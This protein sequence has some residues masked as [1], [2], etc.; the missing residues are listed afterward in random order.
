MHNKQTCVYQIGK[1]Q[2]VP[3]YLLI[4][5]TTPE[6]KRQKMIIKST[7]FPPTGIEFNVFHEY[8]NIDNF[9]MMFFKYTGD[10]YLFVIFILL[11]L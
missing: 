2:D 3:I 11:F 10:F 5:N 6:F 9:V 1:R 8:K 4:I 7:S